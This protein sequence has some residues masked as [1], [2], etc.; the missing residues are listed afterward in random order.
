[1]GGLRTTLVAVPHHGK[2]LLQAKACMWPRLRRRSRTGWCCIRPPSALAAAPNG[3][4]S[5]NRGRA[6]HRQWTTISSKDSM[7]PVSRWSRGSNGPLCTAVFRPGPGG[8]KWML[9]NYRWKDFAKETNT[10]F[11][12]GLDATGI[13]ACR[14]AVE[15]YP[16]STTRSAGEAHQL[17][18]GQN[19]QLLLP[20]QFAGDGCRLTQAVVGSTAEPRGI[21]CCL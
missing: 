18:G 15:R 16:R 19:R 6:S 12:Q 11:A 10:Y 2:Q 8:A 14:P 17:A 20:W 1:M 21:Y 5:H 13:A 9:G 4:S 3:W 7:R